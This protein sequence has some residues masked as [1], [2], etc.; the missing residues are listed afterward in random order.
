M[1]VGA[2]AAGLYAAYTLDNLG[3]SVLILEATDRHG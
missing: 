1:I 3:Y 2:G